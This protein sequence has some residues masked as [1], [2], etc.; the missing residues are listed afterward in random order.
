M[1]GFT[2]DGTGTFG[3]SSGP[4]I[5]GADPRFN[6]FGRL[7]RVEPV[8]NPPDLTA[9]VAARQREDPLAAGSRAI[10]Y[11]FERAKD[12]TPSR[13][14]ARMRTITR[15]APILAVMALAQVLDLA[16]FAFAV[17]RWGIQ[18]ELGPLG[19]VY[20]AAGYWAVAAVKAGMIGLVMAAMVLFRWQRR[21]TPWQIGIV[22][23]AI[24]AFGAATNVAALL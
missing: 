14:S 10:R 15:L 21:S 20:Q 13:S 6:N 24:G 4:E 19:L 23:A 18:G 12:E 8:A 5:G 9:L 1:Q 22:A 16:T 17:D 3:P 7:N 11:A 2:L